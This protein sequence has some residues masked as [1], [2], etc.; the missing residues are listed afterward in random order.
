M[1]TH[2]PIIKL[3][4]QSEGSAWAWLGGLHAWF[5]L[6]QWH[7]LVAQFGSV[8]P[9][10]L[11]SCSGSAGPNRTKWR[12]CLHL[13]ER[14]RHSR[15]GMRRWGS[16]APDWLGA[17]HRPQD[18]SCGIMLKYCIMLPLLS[19]HCWLPIGQKVIVNLII[20]PYQDV[21]SYC[22]CYLCIL[23]F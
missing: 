3:S 7:I 11:I 21:M 4:K 22:P 6:A 14:T 15:Y 18:P 13:A 5:R 23:R 9:S 17:G 20:G 8:R 16:L 10:S 19:M 2:R 1:I 12:D